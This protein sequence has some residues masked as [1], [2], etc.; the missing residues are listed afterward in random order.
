MTI[1]IGCDLGGT[2]IKAGIVDIKLG[3]VLAADSIPTESRQGSDAVMNRMANLILK[4]IKTS[5]FRKH[6]I[7]GLGISAPGMLDIETNTSIFLPNMIG[8]WRNIPVGEKM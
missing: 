8:G 4:L 3:D 1:Y 6:E 7:N 5:G 2:N